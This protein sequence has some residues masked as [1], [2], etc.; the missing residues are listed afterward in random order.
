MRAAI[1]Q[2]LTEGRDLREALT[3]FASRV[4]T[5]AFPSSDYVTFRRLS[6]R[7]RSAPRL[8]EAV[9]ERPERML[10]ERFAQL[11]TDGR[12]RTA[13]PR[14][15]VQHFTALTFLLAVDALDE[16]DPESAAEES[17]ILAIITDG[18]DTFL[19]AYR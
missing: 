3:A 2:E 19:R 1:E 14:R 4:V 11:A 15:A 6:A 12:I 17:E 5:E 13:D 7:G 16:D 9:R 10:E 8:P 18:V